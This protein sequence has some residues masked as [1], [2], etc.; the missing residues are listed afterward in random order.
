VA[1][2]SAR[3]VV[4]Q[5]DVVHTVVDTSGSLELRANCNER[6][7]ITLLVSQCRA[8]LRPKSCTASDIIWATKGRI[9]AGSG[10]IVFAY[11]DGS[12]WQRQASLLTSINS[13]G[14]KLTEV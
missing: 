14:C 5:A 10:L 3:A 7:N 12:L 1:Q 9:G 8:G 6:S 13:S 11:F 4:L 2:E